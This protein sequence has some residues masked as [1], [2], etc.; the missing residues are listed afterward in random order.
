MLSSHV[1]GVHG[2]ALDAS[3]GTAPAAGLTNICN[4]QAN[5]PCLN[6][7]TI[8]CT[9][10]GC[11]ATAHGQLP[12][13]GDDAPLCFFLLVIPT[14]ETGDQLLQSPLRFHPPCSHANRAMRPRIFLGRWTTNTYI[15]S[16]SFLYI[17][18][19]GKYV[20]FHDSR[21][22]ERS[23][24]FTWGNLGALPVINL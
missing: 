22:D 24:H 20:C 7:S 4:P 13:K 17:S 12:A 8:L 14:F 11:R 1:Q 19:Y 16:L 18:E 23:C 6:S 10:R 21:S 9:R 5:C 15:R 3:S 2:K